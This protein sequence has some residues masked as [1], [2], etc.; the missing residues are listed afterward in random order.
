[1]KTLP[2]KFKSIRTI[3]LDTCLS[4]DYLNH[5]NDAL[6]FFEMLLMDASVINLFPWE[7]K[8]YV[9]HFQQS[10][11]PYKDDIL[12]AMNYSSA[13]T[14]EKLN[15]QSSELEILIQNLIVKT[16]LMHQ[17]GES[18]ADVIKKAIP[19]IREKIND[20]LATI[21]NNKLIVEALIK[22]DNGQSETQYFV[23]DI[24]R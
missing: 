17:D 18:F 4:S 14:I 7:K 15:N 3:N 20:L 9:Q 2:E 6:M 21:N 24:G 23:I 13:E 19:N 16:K 8:T 22:K 10:G 12:E 5:F 1:M 11:L